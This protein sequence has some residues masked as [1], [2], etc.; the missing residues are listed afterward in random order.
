MDKELRC[1]GVRGARAC[2]PNRAAE[3][4]RVVD[5]HRAMTADV[6]ARLHVMLGRSSLR[7]LRGPLAMP[8]A[9]PRVSDR[10]QRVAW[11]RDRV[12]ARNSARQE[13]SPVRQAVQR[14]PRPPVVLLLGAGADS[15]RGS[16]L[17]SLRWVGPAQSSG[18]ILRGV[19]PESGQPG[20]RAQDDTGWR[21]SVWLRPQA[22]LRCCMA[23]VARLRFGLSRTPAGGS[24]R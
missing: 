14:R 4:R 19:Y 15:E 7:D 24:D 23:D 16:P 8:E 12:V 13:S 1:I 10:C 5:N 6:A 18:K 21:P 20:R 3:R 11:V 2:P 9:V 17:L 22:A